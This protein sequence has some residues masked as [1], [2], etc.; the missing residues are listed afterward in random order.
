MSSGDE[1][2][3][4]SLEG[5]RREAEIVERARLRANPRPIRPFGVMVLSMLLAIYSI[6]V[7]FFTFWAWSHL[8]AVRSWMDP[9]NSS[10]IAWAVVIAL[11]V[12][13][14]IAAAISYGLWDLEGWSRHSVVVFAAMG[15]THRSAVWAFPPFVTPILPGRIFSPAFAIHL[16]VVVALALYLRQPEIATAFSDSR[17]FGD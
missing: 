17:K 13:M 12:Q 3:Q 16:A 11:P 7:A 10:E 5:T 6:A 8:E 4:P 1:T 14:L 2:P 9:Y 15:L